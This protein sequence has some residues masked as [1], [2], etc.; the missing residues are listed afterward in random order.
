[1]TLGAGSFA[2]L[3]AS[4]WA[5][6]PVAV[7]VGL[8]DSPPLR[9][10]FLRFVLGMVVVLIWALISRQSLKITRAELLPLILLGLLFSVQTAFM[11]L[12]QY[13]TTAGHAGVVITTFPLWA[14]VFA[15]FL[16]PS[17]R[18]S[19]RRVIGA[20]IAYT[21]VVALFVRS[22]IGDVDALG[23]PNVWLGDLLI[24]CSALL[25]GLRQVYLSILGQG[26]STVKML[27]AQG[28]FGC[29]TFLVGSLIFEPEPIRM[30]LILGV[31]LFY[32]GVI[33]AG[34]AFLGQTWLLSNYLPSRVSLIS[35]TSPITTAVLSWLILGEGIGPE[36]W[37][38]AILVMTGSYI[39]Q[40]NQ[41]DAEK[42]SDSD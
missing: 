19:P 32:Q 6:L 12:G 4:L 9:L 36:L 26:I 38:G 25:L 37:I 39:A 14:G 30:T 41:T 17:D 27:V 42:R 35:L 20:I 16:I 23:A 34:F 40:R 5:G 28:I 1:M 13:N 10:G 29:T 7:K 31:S 15:H 3:L 2:F 22:I 33:I 11:N 21:G 18:L 8:E 24:M